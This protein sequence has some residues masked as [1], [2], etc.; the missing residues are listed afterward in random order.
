V[1]LTL[2]VSGF[3]ATCLC[4]R[5]TR[6]FGSEFLTVLGCCFGLLFC[7]LAST[8]ASTNWFDIYPFAAILGTATGIVG[9][10]ALGLICN[11]IGKYQC[12]SS[13]FVFGFMS[14][15]DKFSCGAVILA[16]EIYAPA[17]ACNIAESCATTK[18][19][20]TYYRRVIVLAP[21][22][23]ALS[24]IALL[25]FVLI[26]RKL[27]HHRESSSWNITEQTPLLAN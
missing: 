6:R 14:L 26:S 4:E 24:T 12:T 23:S 7:L 18:L 16:A 8:L 5:L 2:F 15:V 27:A 20:D 25:T 1:P 17:S 11:L 13:G 9:V 21:G 19:Q 22:L 10:S 3:L